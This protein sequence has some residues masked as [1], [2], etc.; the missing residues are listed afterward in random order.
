MR[1]TPVY[2]LQYRQYYRDVLYNKESKEK[3]KIKKP[4]YYFHV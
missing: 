4:M 1:F 3:I 2:M